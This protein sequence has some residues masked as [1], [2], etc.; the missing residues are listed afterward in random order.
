[1]KE[2]I[3]WEALLITAR[4]QKQTR[5]TGTALTLAGK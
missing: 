1:M 4:C 3:Q 2:V 5:K